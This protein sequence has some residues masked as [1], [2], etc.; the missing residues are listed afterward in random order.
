MNEKNGNI[1]GY[2]EVDNSSI[3]KDDSG[4]SILDIWHMFKKHWIG[5][6]AV[7]L[8]SLLIGTVYNFGF[9]GPVWKSQGSAMVIAK[10]ND[11]NDPNQNLNYSLSLLTT[12]KDFMNDEVVLTAVAKD[13]NKLKDSKGKQYN[14]DYIK[15]QKIITCTPRTFQNLERSLYIDVAAKTDNETLSKTLVDSLLKNSQKIANTTND[16]N[17]SYYKI[18]KDVINVTSYGSKPKDDAM[19]GILILA[20]SGGA[21]LIIGLL[22]AI[23][24]DMFN[25]KVT[26]TSELESITGYKVIGVI[27]DYLNGK[28]DEDKRKKEQNKREEK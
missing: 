18:L 5:I 24:F 26:N 27:P 6:V 12:V 17:L 7:T 4:I 2:V 19:S 3:S 28:N 13:V 1:D 8:T 15:L 20:I 21:G 22:Y 16:P 10:A 14:L 11:G 25:T 9:K 23:A